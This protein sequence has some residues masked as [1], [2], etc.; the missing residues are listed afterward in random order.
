MSERRKH[1]ADELPP[2]GSRADEEDDL[3]ELEN[4][5]D[6]DLGWE[7]DDE[8]GRRRDPLRRP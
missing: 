6:L 2:A 8:A 3:P 4:A 5:R 1:P 7:D